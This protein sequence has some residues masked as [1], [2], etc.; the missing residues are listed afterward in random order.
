MREPMALEH[1]GAI[2]EAQA[3]TLGF[4]DGFWL[5]A[6]VF[7]CALIPAYILGRAGKK[8]DRTATVH[9]RPAPQAGD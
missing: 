9:R 2:V 6:G 3:N 1:L 4:Q 7:I 8:P 5:I